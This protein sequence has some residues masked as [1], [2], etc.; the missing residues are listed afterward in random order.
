MN[1]LQLL[2]DLEGLSVLFGGAERGALLGALLF[3]GS[4][5]CGA[6]FVAE[7]AGRDGVP[8]NFFPPDELDSPR[9]VLGA[10]FGLAAGSEGRAVRLVAAGAGAAAGALVAAGALAEPKRD[11]PERFASPFCCEAWA[12]LA[13]PVRLAAGAVACRAGAEACEPAAGRAELGAGLSPNERQPE[14]DWAG[15]VRV[16]AGVL[17]DGAELVR[18]FAAEAPWVGRLVR[19]VCPAWAALGVAAPSVLRA[20]TIC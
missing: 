1:C 7:G 2:L 3:A 16:A 9:F 10:A 6:G 14:F 18:A 15:A 17:R 20:F 13:C 4:L 12:G 19:G 8:L 5:D 11:Q